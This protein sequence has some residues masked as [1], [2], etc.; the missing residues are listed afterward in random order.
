MNQEE[1]N[2][3]TRLCA[4]VTLVFA[5]FR[6]MVMGRTGLGD[7]ESYYWAWAQRPDFSYYDHPPMTAWLI[8]LFTEIGGD[9]TF[10]IRLPSVILFTVLCYLIYRL[11]MDMFNDAKVAFY[12][13][14]TFNLIP[15]FGIAALQIV[16][17]IPAAVCYLAFI[18]G[19]NRLLREDGPA[20]GW[21][22]LGA[23]IGAGLLGKYFVI[24][25]APCVLILVAW[26]PRYRH[27]FLRFQPYMMAPVA[28][29][30][31]LPVIIWNVQ[32]DWPSFKFHLV[33]RH[34]GAG[35]QLKTIA[36]FAAGQLLY[37][38]PIYLAGLLWALWH[39]TVRAMRGDRVYAVLVSFSVP[40][41]AFFYV[42]CMWTNEA[43]PH[44]PAFGYLTAIIMFCALGL[45]RMRNGSVRDARL[46][47]R[48]Y[49][50]AT[51]LAGLV[52]ALFYIHVFH[53]ILPVKPKYDLVNELYGWDQ[54]GLEI[55]KIHQELEKKKGE[56]NV[57]I[58]ARHWVLCSQAM[59]VTRDK[60]PVA[61]FNDKMDQFDFWDDEQRLA[62]KT[63]IMISDLRFQQTPDELYKFDSSREVSVI[64]VIRGGEMKRRF[65]LW[66]GEN[67]QGMKK[68]FFTAESDPAGPP[69]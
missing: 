63:A 30:F 10:M 48:F 57:F 67:Y 12:S 47:R 16:P 56:G 9:S 19:V 21:Y 20:S 54:V 50:A 22:W 41:L 29:L 2:H 25:L 13:L 17:D 55:K 35:F 49:Q 53:P 64:P 38:T 7:S 34:S 11:S 69:S 60:I 28:F 39:G 23:I 26:V 43:E 46:K 14:L 32:N 24:L 27:W 42:V 1:N 61:C 6:L 59:Y 31:F 15:Q 8:R 37:V 45:E 36:E 5:G 58:L 18:V 44:W 3:Y 66:V 52:F 33:D 65:T 4:Y 40:T 51:G 62:G 68:G